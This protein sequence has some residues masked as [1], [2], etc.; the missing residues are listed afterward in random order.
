MEATIQAWLCLWGCAS[1]SQAA[2]AESSLPPSQRAAVW[3]QYLVICCDKLLK[4][5]LVTG[6]DLVKEA[7]YC[8]LNHESFNNAGHSGWNDGK[9]PHRTRC[10]VWVNY[11][12]LWPESEVNICTESLVLPGRPFCSLL[13]KPLSNLHAG[14]HKQK[15]FSAHRLLPTHMPY[16]VCNI[17][18]TSN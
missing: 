16:L 5:L 10:D 7:I 6:A 14:L 13:R 9:N 17:S 1:R 2:A 3:K 18:V 4:A 12:T 11:I 8:A 15:A